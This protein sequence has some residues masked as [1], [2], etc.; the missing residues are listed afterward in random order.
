MKK[1]AQDM[2][3]AISANIPD[4]LRAKSQAQSL[5]WPKLP[6]FWATWRPGKADSQK[7]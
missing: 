4:C 3:K 1:E 2:E 6:A 5:A 7:S